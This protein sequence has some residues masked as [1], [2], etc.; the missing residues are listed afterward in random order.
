MIVDRRQV[1]INQRAAD[2]F[3][4]GSEE[5]IGETTRRLYPCDEAYE[6]VGREALPALTRGEGFETEQELVCKDGSRVWVRCNGKAVDPTDL[7]KGTIWFL[8]DV[9]RAREERQRLAAAEAAL[10]ESERRLAAVLEGSGDGSWEWNVVTGRVTYSERWA[11]MLGYAL[12]EL[13]PDVTTWESLVHPD[14]MPVVQAALR[15]HLEG[16]TPRYESE[17]RVRRKDGGWAWILDRGRVVERAPDGTSLRAAG[18]H[19]DVTQRR[20]AEDALRAA[21]DHVKTL[22]GLLPICMHCK[23][24]RDDK[25]YWDRIEDYITDRTEAEFSHGLCPDCKAR[26]YP[27]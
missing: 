19:T 9:T 10:R 16:K 22:K 6:T 21:L 25:G 1:W 15:P 12:T 23:K 20:D 24:I 3:G 18:T 26:Y 13:A 8:E 11:S 7:S 14:D 4:F 17:H 2:M 27:E 5:L